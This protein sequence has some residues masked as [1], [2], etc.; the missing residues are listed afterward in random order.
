M[1]DPKKDALQRE[2]H[3]LWANSGKGTIAATTGSGKSRIPLL[4]IENMYTTGQLTG[5]DILLCCPTENLRDDN[6]PAEFRN[7]NLEEVMQKHVKRVCYASLSNEKGARYKFIILD[8][9]HWLTSNNSLPFAQNVNGLVWINSN[10]FCDRIMGLTAT[11]PDPKREPFK[12]SL[13]QKICPIVFEYSLVSAVNDGILPDFELHVLL[14]SLNNTN[15]TIPGGTKAKPFKTTEQAHYNYLTK[16]K[17]KA[18]MESRETFT[19]L[20]DAAMTGADTT[21][22]SNKANKMQSWAE[23]CTFRVARFL[24]NLPTKTT[25]GKQLLEVKCKNLKTIVF[26]GGIEQSKELLNEDVYNS[27]DKGTSKSNKL[28]DFKNDLIKHLG[29][30]D[31]VNE[32]QNIPGIECAVII[33]NN[34]RERAFLQRLGRVLR[35]RENYKAVVWWLVV[36]NTED[37]KNMK[38]ILTFLPKEKVH[39]HTVHNIV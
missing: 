4:E 25:L 35:F 8:E 33:H 37:E 36:Q 32:G 27:K 26:C 22:L 11:F 2:A 30:V 13:I 28:L 39:F 7:W 6:W 15:K 19:K 24:A 29:V 16:L 14:C 17:D 23:T 10:V 38:R 5:V 1:M 12:Y 3:F 34:S 18:L 21:E 31:A 9:I 20:G